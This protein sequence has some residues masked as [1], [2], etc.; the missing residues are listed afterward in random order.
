MARN[1]NNSKQEKSSENQTRF[2]NNFSG[3]SKLR[4]VNP[5]LDTKDIAWLNDNYDKLAL[6]VCEFLDALPE[7]YT[8]SSKMDYHS[9]RFSAT[10]VCENG[11]L[12][13]NGMALSLRGATR[14][15][16]LYAL[17]YAHDFKLKGIWAGAG[18]S[19]NARWG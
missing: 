2:S 4:W 9:G 16:A 12:P 19:D 18:D 7:G 13:N 15:D 3:K 11:D 14:I 17:A 8:V 5:Y 1:G 10:C 6:I